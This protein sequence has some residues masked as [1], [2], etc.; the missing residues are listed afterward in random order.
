MGRE[1]GCRHLS[2]VKSQNIILELPSEIAQLSITGDAA[3]VNPAERTNQR[4]IA[5]SSG[6]PVAMVITLK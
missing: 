1:T 5:L 2:S 3:Q 4:F 6:Q